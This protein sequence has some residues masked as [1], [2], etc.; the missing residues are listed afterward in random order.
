MRTKKKGLAY[1]KGRKLDAQEACEQ[2]Q[3]HYRL[4]LRCVTHA[5]RQVGKL[6]GQILLIVLL[7]VVGCRTGSYWDVGRPY[8]D[9]DRPCQDVWD[10]G[11]PSQNIV[12]PPWDVCTP[13]QNIGRSY[14]DPGRGRSYWDAGALPC[15][16]Y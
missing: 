10:I 12:R 11:T 14:W 4:M 5:T 1:W 13:Y 3:E 9:V 2:A 7:F 15:Q 6:E 16:G 8:R